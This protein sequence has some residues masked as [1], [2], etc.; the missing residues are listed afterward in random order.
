MAQSKSQIRERQRISIKEPKNYHVIMHND[1]ITTMDFVIMILKEIF[2]YD[3][4][5]SVD[6]MLQVHNAGKAIV[7]TY[8][9]DIAYS[10][11]QKVTSMAKKENF[12]LQLTIQPEK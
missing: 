4:N 2:L 1:D 9:Y 3:D 6:L 11:V 7:G 12:P 10:K 5:M 8:T